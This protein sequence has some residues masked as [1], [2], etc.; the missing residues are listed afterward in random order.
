MKQRIITALVAIAVLITVICFKSI[1]LRPGIIIIAF[2]GLYEF[3]KAFKNKYKIMWITTMVYTALNFAF[4]IFNDYNNF[5]DEI[6]LSTLM[7]IFILFVLTTLIVSIFKNEVYGIK[8]VIISAFGY[9]YAT[10]LFSFLYLLGTYDVINNS[11][12]YILLLFAI[13]W[14]A[15]TGGYIIGCAIGKH[16]LCEKLS[17]KKTYEGA[18][19][20][21]IFSTLFGLILVYVYNFNLNMI[22]EN[23]FWSMSEPINVL[24]MSILFLVLSVFAQIGDFVASSFKRYVGVKDYSNIMPGHGGIIDRFDSVLFCAPLLYFFILLLGLF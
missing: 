24:K 20:G 10:I 23:E 21:L 17:P 3:L 8:S 5:S 22:G 15:D 13:T 19:G 14:G 7:I 18:V 6:N 11:L 4:L 1:L 16:K 2:C 9:I 12:F